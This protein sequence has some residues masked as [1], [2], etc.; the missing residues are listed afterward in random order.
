MMAKAAFGEYRFPQAR[1]AAWYRTVGSLPQPGLRTGT[2]VIYSTVDRNLYLM[3][4]DGSAASKLTSEGGSGAADSDLSW[5]P[6][7]G[8]IRFC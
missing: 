5:S 1:S 6:D 4:T 8:I 3:K 2:S 7:G